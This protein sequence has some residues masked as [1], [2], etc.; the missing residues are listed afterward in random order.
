MK[1]GGVMEG[2]EAGKVAGICRYNNST[3]VAAFPPRGQSLGVIVIGFLLL[4]SVLHQ[5]DEKETCFGAT[6]VNAS[7]NVGTFPRFNSLIFFFCLPAA[8]SNRGPPV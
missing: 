1:R 2:V 3:I 8:H 4:L 7:I 6:F 5:K